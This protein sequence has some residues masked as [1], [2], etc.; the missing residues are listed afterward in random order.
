MPETERL[1]D[2]NRPESYVFH[3]GLGTLSHLGTA[4]APTEE[5]SIEADRAAAAGAG[6][7]AAVAAA[8]PSGS[9]GQRVASR[10]L[11]ARQVGPGGA[12]AARGV[13]GADQAS[14]VAAVAAIKRGAGQSPRD[15]RAS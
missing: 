11:E 2:C 13:R 15:P 12:G 3:W 7:A 1:L 4:V 5:E 8:A 14:A 10:H 6:P 9:S